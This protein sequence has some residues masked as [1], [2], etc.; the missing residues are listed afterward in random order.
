MYTL[1]EPQVNFPLRMSHELHS[2]FN[3][4]AIQSLVPKSKLARHALASFIH[5]VKT[6]GITNVLNDINKRVYNEEN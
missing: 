6:K 4:I 2:E 3:D 5:D 1:I